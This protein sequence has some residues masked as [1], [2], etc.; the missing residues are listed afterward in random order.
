VFE[1]KQLSVGEDIIIYYVQINKKCELIFDHFSK[2][3]QN[4]LK[5]KLS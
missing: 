2:N 5:E 1:E 3:I 4:R